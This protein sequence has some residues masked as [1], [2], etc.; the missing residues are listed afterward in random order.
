MPDD[1]LMTPW[2]SLRLPDE[3]FS[4]TPWPGQIA[5]GVK[6]SSFVDYFVK[7]RLD[8]FNQLPRFNRTNNY[9]FEGLGQQF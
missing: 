3:E 6:P 1:L 2:G 9:L 7:S 8:D 4:R 5:N